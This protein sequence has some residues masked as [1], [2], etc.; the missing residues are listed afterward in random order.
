MTSVFSFHFSAVLAII[1]EHSFYLW[2]QAPSSKN[3]YFT[4]A[5]DV[6]KSSGNHARVTEAV[7][8]L[9]KEEER[10]LLV[11]AIGSR[12]SEKSAFAEQLTQIALENC[13]G[14]SH[15]ALVN[16]ICLNCVFLAPP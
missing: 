11:E 7:D 15:L 14:V 10:H 9:F 12:I 13:L 5:I 3:E 1:L 8:A 6:Y 4:F 16:L 2:N